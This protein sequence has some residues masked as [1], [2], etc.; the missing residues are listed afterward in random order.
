MKDLTLGFLRRNAPRVP[1]GLRAQR[2]KDTRVGNRG[3]PPI[4]H[5][6]ATDGREMSK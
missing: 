1:G 2:E 5:H 3:L 4:S 6:E